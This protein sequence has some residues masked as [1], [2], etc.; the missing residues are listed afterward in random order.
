MLVSCIKSHYSKGKNERRKKSK[1]LDSR[2]CTFLSLVLVPL[3]L[4]KHFNVYKVNL[5]T[6]LLQFHSKSIFPKVVALQ[7]GNVG[8]EV[9]KPGIQN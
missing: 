2:S 9:S 6:T 1:K 7:Y 5:V 8:F 4:A 3:K